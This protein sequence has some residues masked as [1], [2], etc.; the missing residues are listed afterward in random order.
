MKVKNIM[1]QGTSSSAGKSLLTT[2]LCRIFKN[3][4]YRVS[5][6][7]SQNMTRNVFELK[8]GK[9]IAK[10]QL[11]QA[12]AA[13]KEPN[14]NMN[15]IL[16]VPN[17]ETGSKLIVKGKE[18]ENLEAKK[19]HKEKKKLIDK[20][21]DSYKELEKN[22]DI[23][24]IEGAGSPAEINLRENDFVNMGL[25]HLVDS[26]VILIAD[27]ERGGVFASIYGTCKVLDKFDSNRIKGFIINKFR[28]DS[29]ILNP[30]ILEME[31]R[32]DIPCLGIIPYRKFEIEEE[33]SYYNGKKGKRI[34]NYEKR[35][36]EYEKLAEFILENIDMNKI[37][38]IIGEKIDI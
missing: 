6:F 15:P 4:G 31:K 36:E 28:G 18:I 9:K 35:E 19:Y 5:P 2:A 17:S 37:L 27:I 8:N 38:K 22:T 32:L 16:L 12:E 3:K 25:A 20:V 10:S 34:E 7:K 26:P 21:I 23:I 14:E 13:K 33:D 29:E 30:G 1:I 24:V 11:V